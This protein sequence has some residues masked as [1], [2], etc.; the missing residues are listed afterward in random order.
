M[1]VFQES[2]W[3][4]AGRAICNGVFETDGPGLGRRAGSGGGLALERKRTLP[5]T[6]MMVR[7]EG[8]EKAFLAV[9]P[10]A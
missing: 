1:S 3:G 2:V 5:G 4:R 7:R 6:G 8:K 10:K 9:L